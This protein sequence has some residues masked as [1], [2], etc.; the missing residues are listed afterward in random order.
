VA[1]VDVAVIGAGPGGL[2][3]A[4]ELGRRAVPAVVLDKA[5]QVGASWRGYYERLHMH[6]VRWMSHL[7]GYKIPRSYGTWVSREDVVRYLERYAEHHRLNI[8]L[9]VEVSR[10]DRDG[11]RWLLA[12]AGLTSHVVVV[13]T[14]Y[15]H[16]PDMPHWPGRD[17]FT[18]DLLHASEY[19]N[20]EPF[21]GHDILVAGSG[22]TGTEIGL[23]LAEGG[24]A[25]VRVAV[26]AVPAIVRRQVSPLPNS[27]VTVVWRRLPVRA[28]SQLVAWSSLLGTPDL[29][30]QG[31]P[32]ASARVYARL[33]RE[34]VVPV[35][36][37][38][39]ADAVRA[40][41]I[42]IVQAV[43]GFDGSDVLLA[44]GGRIAPDTVIAATGYRRGLEPLVGHLG[45]L[46]DHGRACTSPSGRTRPVLHRAYQSA[47]RQFPRAENQCAPPGESDRPAVPICV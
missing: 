2:A 39:F 36:D 34:G 25:R 24:A 44:S 5:E 4:A 22:N 20:A 16:T 35:I 14:G 33:Q 46:D 17:G 32:P 12:G 9:G 37:I 21:A 23:D 26:R 40:G 19:R 6:T 8:R 43:T 30:E 18:G 1:D 29:S 41:R 28:T 10:L 7:P 47:Q 27:A 38:G 13:A 42:E 31:L 11:G 3:V 45:V 15:S